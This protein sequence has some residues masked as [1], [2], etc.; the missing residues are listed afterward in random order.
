MNVYSKG[1]PKVCGLDYWLRVYTDI[2]ECGLVCEGGRE[3]FIYIY[4]NV[5]RTHVIS[6]TFIVL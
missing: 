1:I 5:I 4:S 2:F 6:S 3:R